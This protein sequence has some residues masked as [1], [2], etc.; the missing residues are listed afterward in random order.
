M[1]HGRVDRVQCGSEAVTA[2]GDDQP[3]MPTPQAAWIEA[4]QG[5]FPPRLAV[6]PRAREPQQLALPVGPDALGHQQQEPLRAKARP[7]LDP[8]PIQ[9]QVGPILF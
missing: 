3:Q 9:K 1:R 2:M 7:H 5:P 4:L 8:Y 6:S